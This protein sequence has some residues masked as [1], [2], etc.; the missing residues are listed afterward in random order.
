MPT[1]AS[2]IEIAELRKA[3]RH[4][5]RSWKWILA[6]A[7]ELY[8]KYPSG[9]NRKNVLFAI[10][11]VRSAPD[12]TAEDLEACTA[13][14][15][16]MDANPPQTMQPPMVEGVSNPVAPKVEEMATPLEEHWDYASA[17]W[18]QDYEWTSADDR[19]HPRHEGFLQPKTHITQGDIDQARSL[20][21]TWIAELGIDVAGTASLANY[22]AVQDALCS[23]L[24]DA[25]RTVCSENYFPSVADANSNPIMGP[26]LG[27]LGQLH[28]AWHSHCLPNLFSLE[29]WIEKRRNTAIHKEN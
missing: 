4:E 20:V 14:I 1:N 7:R 23:R 25:L 12:P 17:W 29:E 18:K 22:R 11:R 16:F 28:I 15:Q 21:S 10:G 27:A 5:T 9:N 3:L 8:T 26:I 6:K 2:Q 13:L 19:I 24:K